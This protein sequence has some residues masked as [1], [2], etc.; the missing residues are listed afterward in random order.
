MAGDKEVS[1]L[2]QR[3]KKVEAELKI[4]KKWARWVNRHIRI[5]RYPPDPPPYPQ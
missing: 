4:I 5:K 1:K 2:A 3:L